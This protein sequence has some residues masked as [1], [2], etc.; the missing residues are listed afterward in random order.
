MQLYMVH[1]ASEPA[2]FNTSWMQTP[3]TLCF[4]PFVEVSRIVDCMSWFRSQW[5]PYLFEF[6]ELTASTAEKMH[7][8]LSLRSSAP[9]RTTQDLRV[10]EYGVG[11][12]F[13][14]KLEGHRGSSG[15]S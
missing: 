7:P 12:Q 11:R 3:T 9:Q 2:V 10:G 13:F 15:T 1:S 5:D 4:E 14:A 8:A 6:R